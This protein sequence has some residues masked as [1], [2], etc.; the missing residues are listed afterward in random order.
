MVRSVAFA[1][2]ATV[3]YAAAGIVSRRGVRGVTP[4]AGLLLSLPVGFAVTVVAASRSLP[5][6]LA[7]GPVLLLL[8]SGLFAP[9]LG[10]I[11][12]I[13]G[14]RRLGT[15]LHVPLRASV[16]PTLAV[17]GGV[18]LF[19]EALTAGRLLGVLAIIAGMWTLWLRSEASPLPALGGATAGGVVARP[20]R[21]R[22]GAAI[23][24]PV[25]AGLSYGTADL[26]RNH[27][28]HS[29]DYPEF[30]AMLASLTGL[31]LWMPVAA[32]NPVLRSQVRRGAGKRWFVLHGLLSATAVI[33]LMQALSVGEVS[34]VSPILASQPLVVLL[35]SRII[36]RE[37]E[38]VTRTVVVGSL[39]VVTGVLLIVVA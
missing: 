5:P 18:V 16:H 38:A 34:V 6:A 22:V 9:G 13:L 33:S 10:R 39:A 17:V 24:L 32:A 8:A 4:L 37:E 28:L 30:G 23:L 35:M 21:T 11:L 31:L 2:A 15:S 7:A 19:G 1:A 36:L 29:F 25:T 20:P 26:I 27:A 12:N 3:L 14:I